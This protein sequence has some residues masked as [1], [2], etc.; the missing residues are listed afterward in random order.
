M[1]GLKHALHGRSHRRGGS[2]PIGFGLGRMPH[3]NL[4]VD[5]DGVTIVTGTDQQLEFDTFLGVP[6]NHSGTIDPTVFSLDGS[7]PWDHI[8][9]LEPGVYYGEARA[10][11]FYDWGAVRMNLLFSHS[12]VGE[13]FPISDS[14]GLTTSLPTEFGGVY[15]GGTAG[16]SQTAVARRGFIMVDEY[17]EGVQVWAE[18]TNSSGTNRT[19]STGGGRPVGAQLFVIQLAGSGHSNP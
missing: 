18:L 2:D 5:L 15:P 17:A 9:I 12:N 16:S 10:G 3:V 4:R 14:Y 6:I 8:N 13:T 19:A 11:W 7:S 1:S